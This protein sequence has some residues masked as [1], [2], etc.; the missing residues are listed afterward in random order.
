MTRP[1]SFSR[2]SK[3]ISTKPAVRPLIARRSAPLGFASLLPLGRQRE[4]RD[5]GR[6]RLPSWDVI[7]YQHFRT[8]CFGHFSF[9][10]IYRPHKYLGV[11]SILWV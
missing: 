5:R 7:H 10:V 8:L 6:S 1:F 2:P 11:M 9:D 4:V 3:S